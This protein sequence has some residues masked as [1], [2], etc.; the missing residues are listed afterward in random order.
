MKRAIAFAIALA[1]AACG[2]SSEA[3]VEHEAA[4]HANA[5]ASSSGAEN[6]APTI[7][8]AALLPDPAGASDPITLDVKVRDKDRDRLTTT[9]EWYRN[10]SVDSELSGTVV[11]AGTFQRGDRV[12]AMVYVS[13]GH[14]DVNAQ[15]H[16]LTIGNA[17][18]RARRVFVGPNEATA[19]DILV[20]QAEVDDADGDSV[21]LSYR[22]YKNGAEI[23]AATESRLS[24]GTV[25]RGDKVSVEVS[26][27]DGTDQGPWVQSPP[28]VIANA[29]PKITSQPSYEMTPT[30][31]YTYAIEVKDADGDTP[32]RFELVE[33]PPGMTVDASSGVVSWKVPESASGNSK[34]EV[35]VSDSSGGRAT[36]DWI[37][38]V[39][40][41]QP[42]ASPSEG[43]TTKTPAKKPAATA[44]PTE[45]AT[46]QEDESSAE[47]DSLA[48]K[49]TIPSSLKPVR[50]AKANE[51]PATKATDDDAEQDQEQAEEAEEEE[52]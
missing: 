28:V 43:A 18:P 41:A 25:R 4:P 19:G 13:D 9:I 52:F 45:R 36:Q 29:D 47:D 17:A 8:N 37:L 5:P 27:S 44:A 16:V 14:H 40:W 49:T 7:E 38:S 24:P 46:Q 20:A 33:G 12:Y 1:C 34:V 35:A 26:G 30:G 21:Q 11:D 42:P 2:Q 50:P 22:W 32:L 48:E 15:T 6:E 39:D 3:P 31:S 23:P 10:G 51:A